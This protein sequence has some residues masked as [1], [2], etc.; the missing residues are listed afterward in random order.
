MVT[1]GALRFPL[2]WTSDPKVISIFNFVDLTLGDQDVVQEL[3]DFKFMS[4][5]TPITLDRGYGSRIDKYLCEFMV[6][7]DPCLEFVYV[8]PYL[9]SFQCISYK[10]CLQL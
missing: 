7:E 10:K 2:S 5:C 9:T 8:L 1:T 6:K 3:D 4:F